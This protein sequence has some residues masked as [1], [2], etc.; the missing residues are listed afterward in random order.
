MLLKNSLIFF[1][2]LF[3]QKAGVALPAE[4]MPCS[5][6]QLSDTVYIT[7]CE[8]ELDT[9]D[10]PSPLLQAFRHKQKKNK[11]VVATLLAFPF[12]FGIV[13]LHRIYLGCAPYVP[14]A[15]I[16]SL[17][18]VFGILPFIDFCV[19]LLDKD[20]DRYLNNKKIFMWIN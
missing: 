19:L 5:L 15:Y 7:V 1:I 18:G 13:G 9:L 6:T 2:V 17:G 11:K 4:A 16:G 3:I 8:P 14:V 20:I 12:P 10:R